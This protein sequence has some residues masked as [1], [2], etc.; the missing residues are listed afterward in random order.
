[1][2]TITVEQK[3]KLYRAIELA[4]KPGSCS[5]VM[6]GEPCCVIAALAHIEGISICELAACEGMG[7]SRIMT[8]YPTRV[9]PLKDYNADMLR[10]IQREWDAWDADMGVDGVSNVEEVKTRRAS[11]KSI[12]DKHCIKGI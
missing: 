8:D 4:R 11:M 2:D 1:M 12:V 7:I 6:N 9:L 3:E 10:A 5:Y